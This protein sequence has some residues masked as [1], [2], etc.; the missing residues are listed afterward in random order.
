MKYQYVIVIGNGTLAFKCCKYIQ[1]KVKDLILYDTNENESGFLKRKAESQ[2]VMYKHLSKS[3]TFV[4][5]MNYIEEKTAVLIISAVNPWII[6]DYIIENEGVLAINLH[7]SFLPAH[8]GRNA[9]AWA[10]FEEDEY[11]GIT[12]HVISR[13][14]DAGSIIMQ[15]KIPISEEMTSFQLM[16]C[17]NNI[18]EEAFCLFIDEL[19]MGREIELKSQSIGK[20]EKLHYSYE[21]PNDGYLNLEWSGKKI[22]AF[23]RCMDYRNLEVLGSPRLIYGEKEYVWGK[24]VIQKD[25]DMGTIVNLQDD[26]FMIVKDEYKIVLENVRKL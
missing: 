22:S 15:R 24:Y 21:K 23:L 2:R 25:A 18:A 6:P 1:A 11:S 4:D 16:N 3:E 9:E 8:P 13:D 19:L 12:W 5:I 17:Q 7:H 10:I 20:R 14:V 26:C